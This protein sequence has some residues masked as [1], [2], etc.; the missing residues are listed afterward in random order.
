M[1]IKQIIILI[2]AFTLV[3]VFCATGVFA[4]SLTFTAGLNYPIFTQIPSTSYVFAEFTFP[5][6]HLDAITGDDN[7]YP[8]F[9]N[10]FYKVVSKS[11]FSD[12]V[13]YNGT[14]A[15]IDDGTQY[16]G[17]S[18]Q[19]NSSNNYKCSFRTGSNDIHVA[20]CNYTGVSWELLSAYTHISP[21]WVQGD[22]T[23][24]DG[25]SAAYSQSM[26]IEPGYA[27]RI[28]S[29]DSFTLSSIDF[30]VPNSWNF[31]SLSGSSARYNGARFGLCIDSSIVQGGSADS[32][33]FIPWTALNANLFGRA[34]AY[35]Y[36][37]SPDY[38]M[39]SG[40]S[41]VITNPLYAGET[42][43]N[44]SGEF[45]K[46][47]DM[48]VTVY[49]ST[50]GS[51]AFD[52]VPLT[53]SLSA[54]N[55]TFYYANSFSPSLGVIHG[56]IVPGE[57][58]DPGSVDFGNPPEGGGNA[59]Q[60]PLSENTTIFGILSTLSNTITDLF[61]RAGDAMHSLVQSCNSFF[62]AVIAFYGWLP[63]EWSA[64]L[65]SFFIVLTVIG[66]VKLFL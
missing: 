47:S 55:G 2:L 44:E 66:V 16:A 21:Q 39:S 40:T 34:S 27:L 6:S 38:P 8:L 10:V 30:S 52:L 26:T 33:S 4:D 28:Y 15:I 7:W 56:T 14:F 1:T 57:G 43:Q 59:D 24:A 36:S 37:F 19:I 12:G 61:N 41:Y 35:S 51:V 17:H 49:Y 23:Y 53:Q 48:I 46:N 29:S 60:P 13:G 45:H 31:P 42:V 20:S 64:V 62:T 11:T 58:T 32:G 25:F 54:S 9:N 65:W 5:V 63:A 18:F 22:L 50:S 3:A